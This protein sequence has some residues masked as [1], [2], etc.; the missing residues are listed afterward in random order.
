M[1]QGKQRWGERLDS[2]LLFLP[3]F[4]SN[5]ALSPDPLGHLFNATGDQ[6]VSMG[7]IWLAVSS[8]RLRCLF[9]EEGTGCDPGRE[10]ASEL[11]QWG[12]VLPLAACRTE[13][14]Q[15]RC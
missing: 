4:H 7:W 5:S 13:M 3:D 8:L 14:S 2:E 12:S 15:H 1:P 6:D 9:S 10:P 11:P